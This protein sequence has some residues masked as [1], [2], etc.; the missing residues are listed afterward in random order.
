LLFYDGCA[1]ISTSNNKTQKKE[2][3]KMS[4]ESKPTATWNE[5][6]SAE[7]LLGFIARR[8]AEIFSETE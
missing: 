4:P 3:K 8:E 1:L 6:R 7:Q 5:P 2:N